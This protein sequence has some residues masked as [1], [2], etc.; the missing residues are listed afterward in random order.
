MKYF[1]IIF[2]LSIFCCISCMNKYERK[3]VGKYELYKYEVE[4]SAKEIDHFSQLKLNNNKSFELTYDHKIISGNW[5]VNDYGDFTLL[6]LEYQT[7]IITAQIGNNNL[8]F[9]S[10]DRFNISNFKSLEFVR[11]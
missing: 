1:K 3:A 4:N 9:N 7:K 6:E 11:L 8:L 5:N 10:L 2:I